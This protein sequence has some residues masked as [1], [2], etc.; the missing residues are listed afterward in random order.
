MGMSADKISLFLIDNALVLHY[1]K[2]T[3]FT[4]TK[5]QVKLPTGQVY[6]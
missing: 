2:C 5:L 1:D 3:I 4:V 6:E